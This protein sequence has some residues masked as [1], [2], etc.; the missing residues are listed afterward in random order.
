M[1]RNTNGSQYKLVLQVYMFAYF[2]THGSDGS[3]Q[4]WTQLMH[5]GNKINA[6]VTD[7]FHDSP[8]LQ[9]GNVAIIRL[10]AGDHIWLEAYYQNEAMLYGSQGFTSFSG[11]LLY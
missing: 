11:I 5:N 3:G 1:F 4:V 7:T 6:G 2:I 8:P 10:H 9:G